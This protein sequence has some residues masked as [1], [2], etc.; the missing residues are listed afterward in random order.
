MQRRGLL[1]VTALTVL[2]TAVVLARAGWLSRPSARQADAHGT[3]RSRDPWTTEAAWRWR[4]SQPSHW[5][6]CLLQH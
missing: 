6:A 2:L 3:A 4:H 1:A 5:R